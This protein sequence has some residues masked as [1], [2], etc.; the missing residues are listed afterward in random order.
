[1]ERKNYLK[2]ELSNEEKLYLKRTIMT[3]RNLYIKKN[4]KFLKQNNL[5]LKE[6][7]FRTGDSFID[8]VIERCLQEVKSA[9]KFEETLSNPVLCKY[10]KALSLREKEVLFYL[11]WK[12]KQVN[13]TA[14]ILGIHR[15]AVGKIRDRAITKIAENML[16]EE[17]KDV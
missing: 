8:S 10:V 15:N 11:F 17:K 3:A 9:E 14:Q 4:R 16:K 13:D 1:M 7:I 5:E 12:E 6:E 2:E